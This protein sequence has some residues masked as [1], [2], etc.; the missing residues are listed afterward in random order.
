MAEF[1][2]V[3]TNLRAM[4]L[5]AAPEC[6]VAKDAPGDFVLHTTRL[7]KNGKPEWFGAVAIKKSYVSY[8]IFPLYTDPSIGVGMTDALAKRQQGKSCFNFKTGEPALFAEL[9][10]LTKRAAQN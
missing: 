2:A 3:F 9:A 5:A 7:D 10:H 6:T 4:M 1:E 8:H